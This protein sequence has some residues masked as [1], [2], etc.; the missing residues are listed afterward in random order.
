MEVRGDM[1]IEPDSDSDD[2]S[3]VG[4][5]EHAMNDTEIDNVPVSNR[6]GKGRASGGKQIFY[7][8]EITL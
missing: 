2:A 4:K 7:R 5:D 6:K 8:C 1:R 3:I